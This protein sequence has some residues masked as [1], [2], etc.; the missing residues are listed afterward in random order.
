LDIL[1]VG[2]IQIRLSDQSVF[3][4]GFSQEVKR[5]A[6]GEGLPRDSGIYEFRDLGI[7]ELRN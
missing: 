3:L 6:P 1:V 4:Y 5:N 2:R 7:E